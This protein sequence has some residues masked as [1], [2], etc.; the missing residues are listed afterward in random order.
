MSLILPLE[1]AADLTDEAVRRCRAGLERQGHEVQILAVIGPYEDVPGTLVQGL[2]RW[3]QSDRQGLVP[4]AIA[5]LNQ[6]DGDVLL[7]LDLTEGYL[8]DD[9]AKIVEPIAKERAE[10]VVAQRASTTGSALSRL[11]PRRI[12]RGW[13]GR[14]ALRVLG[15]SDP[16]SGLVA[17][18]P[19]LLPEI[20]GNYRPVGSRFAVDLLLRSRARKAEVTVRTEAPRSRLALEI[21][22]LRHLK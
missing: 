13:L 15:S 20:A 8:P 16:F 6:A 21:D 17:L 5:G 22:D 12:A 14:L 1:R 7:V 19:S 10:L 3:V 4:A 2:D 9:L 18:H 11:G